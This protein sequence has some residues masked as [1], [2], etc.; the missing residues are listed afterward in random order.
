MI[1][2]DATFEMFGYRSTDLK[3]KSNRPIVAVCEGKDCKDPVRVVQKSA[4]RKL[5]HKCAMKS[6]KVRGKIQETTKKAM[7]DPKVR[8]RYEEAMAN[9]EVKAKKVEAIKKA[10]EDPDIRVMY[11]KAITD[12]EVKAKRAKALE[13]PE[14]KVKQSEVT[15]KW[16]KEMSQG[17]C[18]ELAIL[19][20]C[21]HQGIA[22][23]KWSRFITGD[24]S[25]L[26]PVS[27]CIQINEK[28][29]EWDAHHI[30]SGAVIFIPEEMHDFISHNLKTEKNIKEI[31]E[32][33]L[34][35]MMGKI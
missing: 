11:M 12:P 23:D 2:E 33:A 21:G 16:R 28:T 8:T 25:H 26:K 29:K 6:K 18:N 30:T 22:R 13:D 20:S 7:A 27:Q 9:P 1:D 14:F 15:K 10:W 3:K 17:E 32:L 4:Y 19:I 31:N 35:F 5:C 34:Q 24:Q